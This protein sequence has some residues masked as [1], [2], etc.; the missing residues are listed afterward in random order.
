MT[1]AT[2]ELAERAVLRIVRGELKNGKPFVHVMQVAGAEML[3]AETIRRLE[4][5]MSRTL[6]NAAG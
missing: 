5:A 4:R 1:D 6:L 2:E 3:V